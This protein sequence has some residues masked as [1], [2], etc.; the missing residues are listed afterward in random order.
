LFRNTV[1][2]REQLPEPCIIDGSPLM[3]R[4]K[5]NKGKHGQLCGKGFGTRHT[6]LRPGMSI[7]ALV[8]NTGDG[9]PHDVAYA[10]YD[11]APLLSVFDRHQGIGGFPA[12]GYGEYNIALTDNR[13]A[14]PELRCIFNVYGY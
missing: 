5:R 8:R 1:K 3:R 13:I 12:L 10:E 9:R 11:R 4:L 6:D 14:I 2:F 7:N